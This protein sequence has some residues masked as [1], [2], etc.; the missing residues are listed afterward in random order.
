MK[1]NR[2][3]DTGPELALRRAMYGTGLRYRKHPRIAVKSGHVRPD[4]VLTRSR[5]A[6]FVSGCFWHGCPVHYTA[7]KANAYF[8]DAKRRE[9]RRRDARQ[10]RDLMA[11]GWHVVWV[12][13]HED[14]P[15]ASARVR[16]AHFKRL[17]TVGQPVREDQG[18]D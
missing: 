18:H 7:P 5:T 2:A 8:W 10:R 16:D 17:A 4:I 13:E 12:W 6:V 14:V 15:M 1:S 3:F 9:N 11:A